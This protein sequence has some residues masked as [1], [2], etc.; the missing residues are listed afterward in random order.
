MTVRKKTRS[1]RDEHELVCVVTS[2]AWWP[3]K[4]P[5]SWAPEWRSCLCPQS[6]AGLRHNI[7]QHRVLTSVLGPLPKGISKGSGLKFTS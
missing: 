1:G 3:G 5:H 4:L 7:G 6:C 2:A